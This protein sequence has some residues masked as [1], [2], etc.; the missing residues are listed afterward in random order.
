M[1]NRTS[2]IAWLAWLALAALWLASLQLR[3]LLDPDEGRYAE[4]PREMAASG[5]WV[6]PRLNDLKYFEKPP[7]QYWMTA[8]A[9]RAFGQSPWS[10]RLWSFALAFA[11]LPLVFAWTRRLYG[12]RS[13][14]AALLALAVS[15]YFAIVGHLNLLDSGFTFWLTATVLAFLRAQTSEPGSSAERRGCC[16]VGSARHWPCSA[17]E[18]S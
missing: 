2:N 17:K 15:P 3:P 8:A 18:S 1:L 5:D 9:Y 12:D 11:C 16:C 7:L 6:T 14:R 4:I 10:S 13:G